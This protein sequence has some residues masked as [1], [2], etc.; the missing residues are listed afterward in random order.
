MRATMLTLATTAA[1]L[2]LVACGGDDDSSATPTVAASP[3]IEIAGEQARPDWL[4]VR[5]PLPA[6]TTLISDSPAAGGGGTAEFLAPHEFSRALKFMELNLGKPS[7][8]FIIVTSGGNEAG[9]EFILDDQQ[10]EYD[11]TVKFKPGGEQTTIF[12]P[13]TE[14]KIVVILTPK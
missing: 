14:T 7:H 13:G 12:E 9:G 2:L 3:T 10:G 1:L 11:G 8:G 5:F 6:G 4:P